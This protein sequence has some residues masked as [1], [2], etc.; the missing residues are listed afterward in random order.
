MALFD[1]AKV[2]FSRHQRFTTLSMIRSA[3]DSEK[4]CFLRFVAGGDERPRFGN[5]CRLEFFDAE[6][7]ALDPQFSVSPEA[8]DVTLMRGE[9][10]IG[11]AA[12][13]IGEG[14]VLY[15]KAENIE[16]RFCLEGSRYDYAFKA[17][18]GR[19]CV[20]AAGENLK[21]TPEAFEGVVR[22]DGQWRTDHAQNV[23]ICFSGEKL[24]GRIILHRRLCPDMPANSF[25]KTRASAK[26]EFARWCGDEQM[27]EAAKLA[28]YLLWANTV[29]AG[30]QLSAPAIYMSKN[31]MINIWSW[32]NA[33][34]AIG[35]AKRHPQLAFDQFAV[36][37]DQQDDSGLLPD[38]VHD[39]GAS[40]AFTKPPV[41]GWAIE[42]IMGGNPEAFNEDQLDYLR[43]KLE[44]QLSYWL[45]N[46]RADNTQLPSYAHG[47]DSGWDNASFFAQGG[48]VEGPDLPTFLA[49]TARTISKMHQQNGNDAAAKN[50][51]S[52][53]DQL[54]GLLVEKLWNGET[55]TARKQADP[56]TPLPGD[57]LIQYMPLLLGEKLPKE[58][59]NA[60]LAKLESSGILTN[61]GPA[62]ENPSSAFYTP[63]GYWRGP[64]WAPTTML[65]FDGLMA[66]NATRLAYKVANRF[67]HLCETSGMAENFDAIDGAGVRDPAFAWT[68]AVYLRLRE[69][70]ANQNGS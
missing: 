42:H 15:L 31:R 16:V 8:L 3:N 51:R 6:G 52:I 41:H 11:K 44:R 14:E 54:I 28:S 58:I 25:E 56:H 39:Q 12:F 37:F 27:A 60:L 21:L 4:Q 66:Q 50:F 2:P 18:D 63:D 32:D 10:Q 38:Y 1:F 5:L 30:G 23:A 24:E 62:T 55:F 13:A 47:N 59:A 46:T 48:P 65:L 9:I 26:R 57:S 29:P 53:E 36:I 68:S 22:V 17:H 49:L 20:V 35:V 40:F 7:I 70:L 33:F 67:T 19:D 34:S 69:I 45:T 61:W 43:E 64:I